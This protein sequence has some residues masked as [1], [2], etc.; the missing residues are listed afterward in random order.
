MTRI[1]LSQRI[2][3]KRMAVAVSLSQSF[4]EG[5]ALCFASVKNASI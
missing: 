1:V 5:V 4:V 3:R 2:V